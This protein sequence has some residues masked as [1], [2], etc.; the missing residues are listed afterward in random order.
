MANVFNIPL[1]PAAQTFDV[2]LNG[3]DYTMRL[4][5]NTVAQ[6]WVL[7]IN[8]NLGNP[9]AQGI[10]LLDG[11]DMLQQLA[12]FGFGGAMMV[13]VVPSFA[14]LGTIGQLFFLTP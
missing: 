12:S 4:V 7:D 8:D 2:I 11:A 14:T 5:W 1:A 13:D 6:C 10:P 9:I 3:V